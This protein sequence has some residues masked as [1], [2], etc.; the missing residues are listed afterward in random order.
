MVLNYHFASDNDFI[1]SSLFCLTVQRVFAAARAVFLQFHS[2]RVIPAVFLGCVVA[3]FAF[4]TRQ[5]YNWANTLFL[6]SHNLI[7][8]REGLTLLYSRILV[9]T[10]AP[11]VRPPS[12]IANLE[13]CSRATGTI[14]SAVRLILSPGITISVP[15]G[16]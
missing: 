6:G 2:T 8:A 14:S 5:S 11:T 1:I 16:R 3:F 9:I 13:P 10:P 12:R 4:R 7:A 15:S